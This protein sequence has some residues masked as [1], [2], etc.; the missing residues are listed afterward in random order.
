MLSNLKTGEPCRREH[1]KKKYAELSG[2]NNLVVTSDDLSQSSDTDEGEVAAVAQDPIPI[3]AQVTKSQG[4]VFSYPLG[5]KQIQ[6]RVGRFTGKY[7]EEDFEA[8]L[9]DFHEATVDCRWTDEQRA[10]WFSRFLSGVAKNT[11]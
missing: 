8:W 3:Q 11:W 1:H 6:E 4:N 7:G 2:N 10:K 9:A 5:F